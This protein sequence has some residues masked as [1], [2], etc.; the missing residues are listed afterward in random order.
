MNE[1]ITTKSGHSIEII[2]GPRG[3]F[4]TIR[5]YTDGRPSVTNRYAGTDRKYFRPAVNHFIK[6]HGGRA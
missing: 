6:V 5:H 1:T 4:T 3:S 2:P